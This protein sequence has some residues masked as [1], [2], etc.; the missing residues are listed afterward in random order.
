MVT[1][2]QYI[3]L[4]P[5]LLFFMSGSVMGMVKIES[6]RNNSFSFKWWG[7][8]TFTGIMLAG[9]V[10]VKFV[11]LFVVLLVGLFT[12]A[13]LWEILGDMSQ[14]VVS[15]GMGFCTS[16]QSPLDIIFSHFSFTVSD[17]YCKTFHCQVIVPNCSSSNH[18]HYIFLH[19][20]VDFK[21]KWKWRWLLLFS[22]PI[23]TNR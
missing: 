17:I 21:Q 20:F 23:K 13:E 9:A 19:S 3:L 5:I 18:V 22:L 15:K 12:I 4:D 8:L 14:P 2:N 1:L 11:G 6:Q 10:S 7:W 16:C